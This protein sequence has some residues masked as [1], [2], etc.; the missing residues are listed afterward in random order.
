MNTS[1]TEIREAKLA[2]DSLSI[3]RQLLDDAVLKKLYGLLEYVQNLGKNPDLD[4]FIKHYGSFCFSLA[5]SN[6]SFSLKDYIIDLILYDDNAF[7]MAAESISPGEMNSALKAGASQDLACLHRVTCLKPSS[8]KSLVKEHFT[9]T[10][11]E[12]S[13]IESL[14]SWTSEVSRCRSGLDSAQPADEIRALFRSDM[15]W[16]DLPD[17]LS[18][19]FR[20]NG[21][22]IYAKYAAFTWEHNSEGGCLKGVRAPD[23][24]RLS[25]LIGYDSERSEVLDNTLK[26]LEGL[27]ANNM[28]LYGDRG[29]GKSSTVKAILNE[30][31]KS[32]LRL[33]EVPKNRLIDFPVIAARLKDSSMK[34]II[35]VDDLA[36]EDNEEN[37]TALKAVL[38]G[39]IE[40]RP[41]NVIIYATSNRRHLIKERF[42]DRAGLSSGD[43]DDEVRSADTM[44][45]KLSLSDRFG[46]T[47]IFSAPD[48]QRYLEIVEGIARRRGLVINTEELHREALKWELWY[49]GRSPRTARQFVDWLEG[50]LK[51]RKRP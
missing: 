47:V 4:G 20:R 3:Y 46:I 24:V 39:G 34:F 21:R 9:L 15:P 33:V 32:G 1:Y 23:P 41:S 35:F 8:L 22:G 11:F 30:Y 26:F 36:F 51:K 13:V 25:D 40:M 7:T 27:P 45:E 16:K 37:Y 17:L 12:M 14:P 43:R 49:N 38:E 48:K 18:G 28:L 42:S 10:G 29:T 6:P 19:F 50:E 2:L 44:Q 5:A 31:R